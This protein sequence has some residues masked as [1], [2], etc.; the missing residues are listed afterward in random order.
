LASFNCLR[1]SSLDCPRISY[2]LTILKVDENS[3]LIA[4]RDTRERLD[5]EIKSIAGNSV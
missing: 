1:S 4:G 3:R 5:T 2:A